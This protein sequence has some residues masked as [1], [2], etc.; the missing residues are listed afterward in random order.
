MADYISREAFKSKYLCCGYLPE[1]SE[2]EFDKFPAAD[3]VEV[4]HGVWIIEKKKTL[5]PVEFD[6][7][8]EPVMHEY[9]SYRCDRCG[10]SSARQEPYCHCGAKMVSGGTN[11]ADIG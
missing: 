3:V 2:E 4:V 9:V 7:F 11:D 8:D 10:R 1:M 5:I 6:E